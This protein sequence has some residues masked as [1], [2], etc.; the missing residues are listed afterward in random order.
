LRRFTFAA[1]P[2]ETTRLGDRRGPD[3]EAGR[4]RSKGF[5]VIVVCATLTN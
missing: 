1:E 3:L 4:C 2:H 5:A